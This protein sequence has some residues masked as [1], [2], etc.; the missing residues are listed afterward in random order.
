MIPE[1]EDLPEFRMLCFSAGKEMEQ[2]R[3]A[4]VNEV[5][6]LLLFH[7]PTCVGM[8]PA[9]LLRAFFMRGDFSLLEKSL[10]EHRI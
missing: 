5:Y 1:P 8:F 4:A 2:N 7:P 6:G 3:D 10:Q 9:E